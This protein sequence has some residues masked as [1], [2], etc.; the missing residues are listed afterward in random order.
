MP[1][2]SM[3]GERRGGRKR[4]TP[5]RTTILADRMVAVLEGFSTASP[6]EHLAMLVN[7]QELPGDIRLALA[8]GQTRRIP[9]ARQAKSKPPKISRARGP[10][11]SAAD[12]PR[13]VEARSAATAP[14]E[15][16]SR[17]TLDALFCIVCD[18]NAPVYA[19]RKAAGKLA[20]YFLP[21]KLVNKR[22]RFT[23]DEY[24]FA[25]NAEIAR[26]YRDIDFE[27]RNLKRHPNRDFPEFAQRI[28]KLQARRD[29]IWQRL[30]C[31][32]PSR[33]GVKQIQ[34]EYIRLVK[35]T[36]QREDASH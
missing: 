11:P 29:A 26:E 12:E 30:K 3:P 24:G 2:G 5:N 10:S 34:E 6:K 18:A 35:F 21:K 23:A 15:T 13:Q 25:I 7:D 8:E 28:A 32:C 16:M 27:L 31:P 19:R 1:R 14:I 33:Y 22:W 36:P 4:A 17:A 9:P 20:A